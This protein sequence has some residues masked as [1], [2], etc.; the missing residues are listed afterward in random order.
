MNKDLKSKIIHFVNQCLDG[1]SGYLINLVILELSKIDIASNFN[2]AK[3]SLNLPF[4]L[5]YLLFEIITESTKNNLRSKDLINGLEIAHE[6]A[7]SRIEVQPR[8]TAVWTG[9]IFDKRLIQFETLETVKKLIDSA[10]DEIFIVGY[11]FSFKYDIMKELLRKIESAVDRNCRIN[12]IVNNEEGVH[13]E[14]INNWNKESYLLNI[15]SWIG[16]NNVDYTSLHSKL[17]IIDQKKMLLTSANF[18]Y[19][20]FMKNI[21]TGVVIENHN[22]IRDIWK[23]FQSLLKNN[24]MIKIY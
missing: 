20:G 1:N 6:M 10:N 18:S 7:K 11:N 16:N 24:Q 17:I 3:S 15:Y 4:H 12:L 22:V 14:I 23:Q 8:I 5:E 19:H 9:P 2:Q 21:E 13:S